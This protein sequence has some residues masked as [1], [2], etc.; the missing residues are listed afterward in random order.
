[1]A[2][3]DNDNDLKK[4]DLK[5]YIMLIIIVPIII[6]CLITNN[7][8]YS[9]FLNKVLR[10]SFLFY[11]YNSNDTNKINKL[12]VYKTLIYSYEFIINSYIY[13]NHLISTF[14]CYDLISIY[15]FLF[16]TYYNSLIINFYFF[17]KN[18]NKNNSEEY[19]IPTSNNLIGGLIVNNYFSLNPHEIL[20]IVERE[21][22]NIN[23]N[24]ST[25]MNNLFID[26]VNY[27]IYN[28]E[29]LK[30]KIDYNS[31]NNN[32]IL[33]IDFN[34]NNNNYYYKELLNRKIN[35]GKTTIIFI[36]RKLHDIL[37]FTNNII[38][39]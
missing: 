23:N 10:D 21:K 24:K 34:D 11:Y 31:D 3:N 33:I 12:N 2:F 7:F 38:Y 9:Y 5:K 25:I 6:K 30:T 13:K 29:W 20:G 22:G 27:N 28:K 39:I 1:M 26:N 16:Y 32:K 35:E 36:S 37:E 4:F 17:N 19:Y 14:D 8:Y 18:K 15:L